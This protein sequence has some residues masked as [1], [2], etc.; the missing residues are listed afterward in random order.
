MRKVVILWFT[1]CLSM[2]V[3]GLELQGQL[4]QGSLIRATLPAGSK[5]WLNDEPVT[6]SSDGHLAFGFGRDAPLS[7]VV[8][9]QLPGKAPQQRTLSLT[10]R[11]YDIQEIDGLPPKMVTPDP[12]VLARIKEDSRKVR[13][14]RSLRDDRSDFAVDF[15]WPAEGP[16]SGVYGS[17]R[18]LN[19]EPRRPHFGVDVAGPTGTPV[20]SPAPGIV[21]LWA[22]DMYYSGGTL[23]I[24]HGLGINS[25]FLHLSKGHV[26]EGQRVE[27]GQ[28]VGEIG[29]TG[30]ATG[31]HLDWRLNWGN[32]RLDP[33]L[34]VPPRA[35]K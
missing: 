19:G 26:S 21:T 11:S 15:Q 14:A 6:V 30:R 33:A 18:V 16:I 1:L 2:G 7:H 4:T 31:P 29:A 12:S 10:P 9:W 25:T 32:E 27:Q 23:I 8:R 28:L 13:E 22:P 3:N 5:V 35:A 34:L 24:D 20:V 17:Q